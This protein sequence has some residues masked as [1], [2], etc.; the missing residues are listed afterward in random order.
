[1]GFG[2][3]LM[4]LTA[5]CLALACG[6]TAA[7][8]VPSPAGEAAQW[9]VGAGAIDSFETDTYGLL[10]V[11]H[12]FAW[13]WHGLRLWTGALVVETGAFWCGGGLRFVVQLDQ[14]WRVGAASGPGYFNESDELD[15][16]H[17]VEL[18]STIELARAIGGAGHLVVDVGHM[19]NAGLGDYNP[20]ATTF[21]LSFRRDY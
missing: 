10:F 3:I 8:V 19:S 21:R 1:M 18:Y 13:N 16:G 9:E 4:Q 6:G 7:A 11:G 5:A 15:L 14:N 20:G 12:N 17:E 2:R